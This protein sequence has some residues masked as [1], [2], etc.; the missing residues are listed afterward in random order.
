MIHETLKL[1]WNTFVCNY[2]SIQWCDLCVFKSKFINTSDSFASPIGGERVTWV[3]IN[4]CLWPVK[5]VN[6]WAWHATL[7]LIRPVLILVESNGWNS[8]ATSRATRTTF[9]Y[10]EL[11][12]RGVNNFTIYH[13]ILNYKVVA[14]NSC[15]KYRIESTCWAISVV[16]W[17][18]ICS[19]I[20]LASKID[21]QITFF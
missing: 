19:I 8:C 20:I 14:R 18:D 10:K 12:T 9:P 3:C 4:P 15:S 17:N 6:S 1:P 2:K 13:F 7:N 11:F 21:Q 5:S 16:W